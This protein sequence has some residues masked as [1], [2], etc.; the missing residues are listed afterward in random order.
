VKFR[1]GYCASK[2]ALQ[3]FFESFRL[4]MEQYKMQVTIICP[5][6]VKTDINRTRVGDAKVE[7][8]MTQGMSAEDAVKIMVNSIAKGKREL[9]MTFPAKLGRYLHLFFPEFVDWLT[10]RKMASISKPRTKKHD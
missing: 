1:T 10:Q 6:Q 4:E 9:V 2:F 7:L 3:G 8:D 5:G